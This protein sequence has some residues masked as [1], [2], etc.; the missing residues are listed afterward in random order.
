MFNTKIVIINLVG[1]S[2][3]K[4]RAIRFQVTMLRDAL[5]EIADSSKE[6]IVMAEAKDLCECSREF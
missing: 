4:V 6:D 1:K 3:R 5:V 2:C